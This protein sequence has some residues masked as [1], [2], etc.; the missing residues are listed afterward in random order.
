MGIELERTHY[1]PRDKV[2]GF[3]GILKARF[4][5]IMSSTDN[6]ENLNIKTVF[7]FNTKLMKAKEMTTE[8]RSKKVLFKI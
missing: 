5:N 1:F 2:K 6:A 4:E 7:N 3:T 8:E